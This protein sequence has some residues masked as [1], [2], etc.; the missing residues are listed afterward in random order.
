MIVR[1][2]A[3]KKLVYL[4][5]Y[6]AVRGMLDDMEL[7]ME[8]LGMQALMA[9][10]DEVQPHRISL[11]SRVVLESP[12]ARRVS[13]YLC[14]TEIPDSAQIVHKEQIV[15]KVQIQERNGEM[16]RVWALIDCGATSIFMAPRLLKR[17]GM[18]HEAAHIPTFGL[19][20]GVMQHAKDSR[21]TRI[22]VQCLDYLAPVDES[23][24]LVVPMH[25]Y[26][27]VL[28]LPWFH[29]RNPYIDWAHS[30]LTCLGSLSASG[31]EEMTPM[32][33][34]VRSKVS[35]AENN[36]VND[37]LLGCGPDIQT[38]GATAFDD[39]L[40]RDEVVAAFALR[41]GECTGLLGATLEDR[42]LDSPGNTDPSAGCDEQG[43][44][45]VVAAEELLR[46]D[47]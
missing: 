20:R 45:A 7:R 5:R 36:N 30:R 2:T 35:E 6:L 43:A 22:T 16:Q 13:Q 41:I 15:H 31:V 23:D 38:L 39:L 47:A 40:G 21:N 33:T 37:Q 18:S 9:P 8:K 42:T 46:G 14:G 11:K 10:L 26:D 17:L 3:S 29:K 1:H 34:A 12:R 44:A 4:S 25:A 28:G 19:N 27:L 24:M 32:T